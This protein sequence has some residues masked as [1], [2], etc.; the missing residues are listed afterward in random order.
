M[1]AA[2]GRGAMHP[3]CRLHPDRRMVVALILGG[4]GTASGLV[5]PL[6]AARPTEALAGMVLP[7]V[8]NGEPV[9]LGAALRASGGSDGSKRTLLVLGTHAADF[10]TAEYGIKVRAAWPELQQKGVERCLMVVNGQPSSCAKLAELLDLPDAFELLADPTGE[11]GRRFGVSRGFRPDDARLSPFVKLFA[12]G[13]GVGPPWMTLPAVLSGYI[14]SPSGSNRWIEAGLKQGQLADRWPT[15]LELAEDGSVAYN[16][17][18]RTPLLGGWGIRPFET[19]TLRLQTL[20]G[21]QAR[22]WEALKPVD[23]RCLTQLGGCTIVGAAGECIFSWVDRG[24][25]DVPDM[26]AVLKSL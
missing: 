18:A 19:A 14:G 23:D 9:D 13:I 8:S 2:V 17:F 15:I 3:L 4:L 1:R 7:R 20:V 21:V 10:N 11:A 26:E 25:C 12:M 22:H 16:K 24:L 5:V 6:S